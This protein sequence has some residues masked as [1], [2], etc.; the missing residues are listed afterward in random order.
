MKCLF[1][2][3]FRMKGLVTCQNCR[4]YLQYEH[5]PWFRELLHMDRTQRRIDSYEISH[6]GY[7]VDTAATTLGLVRFRRTVG[8]PSKLSRKEKE[9]IRSLRDEE[10]LSYRKLHKRL[11]NEYGFSISRE[12]VRRIINARS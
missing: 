5:E 3:N 12:T 10:H 6:L 4:A 9:F 11:V 8:A 2:D 1:C 7:L